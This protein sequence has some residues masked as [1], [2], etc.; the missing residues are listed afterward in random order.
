MDSGAAG[1]WA[2]GTGRTVPPSRGVSPCFPRSG[3]RGDGERRAGMSSGSQRG[4]PRVVA[5]P[6]RVVSVLYGDSPDNSTFALDIQE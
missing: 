5:R 4:P 1:A 6:D 2:G 3:S